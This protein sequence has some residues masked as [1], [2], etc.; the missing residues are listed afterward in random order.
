MADMAPM[1]V[2]YYAYGLSIFC[3]L[4]IEFHPHGKID[5]MEALASIALVITGGVAWTYDAYLSH[6]KWPQMFAAHFREAPRKKTSHASASADDGDDEQDDSEDD[7]GSSTAGGGPHSSG[8]GSATHASRSGAV[9]QADQAKANS[10]RIG[11][12]PQ[13]IGVS[14]ANRNVDT[15]ELI[16]DCEDCPPLL[17]VPAGTATIGASDADSDALMAERPSVP[18]RFWPG[19][20]IGA[21]PVSAQ[22]FRS[23]QAD[24]ARAAVRCGPQTADLSNSLAAQISAETATAFA[25]CVTPGDADAYVN[26]LTARTGK[27]FHLVTAAEWEYAAQVLPAPGLAAGSVAEIVSDCWHD[28]VPEQGEER[29]ASE[30]AG[31]GCA[32][33]ML[34]G[35]GPMEPAHWH[36]FSARRHIGTR[37]TGITVGFRVMRSFDGVR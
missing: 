7:G 29:I 3:T 27:R 10:R 15:A 21:E 14:A 24:T 20:M 32:G 12:G 22:S 31:L 36:R 4:A 25:T 2:V 26:W 28:R 34:K 18:V 35:A 8:H 37:E 17:S 5:S 1:D 16:R 11:T 23:F 13:D 19:F 30:T 33:R 6:E 9:G